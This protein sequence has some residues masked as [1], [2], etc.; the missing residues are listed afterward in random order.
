MS[1]SAS[2]G[3]SDKRGDNLPALKDV[4][5]AHGLSAR[6]SLGQHF[7]LDSGITDRIARTAGEVS[8]VNVIEIGPGPGGLTRSLLAAGAKKIFAVEKDMRC[9]AALAEIK[10]MAGGRLEIIEADAL[11]TDVTA[12]VP[13][14]RRIVANL[15]YNIGTE[16]LLGWLDAIYKDPNV[17][18]S[19]T[20]MF[21]KEVAERIAARPSTK[22]YGRLSV[23]SQWLCETRLEFELP[24][25]A[26]SPPPK[27]S[28][29]VVTLTPRAAPLIDVEKAVLEKVMAAAFGQRRKMLRQSLKPLGGEALLKEAGIDPTQRPEQLDVATLCNLAKTYQRLLTKAAS[30]A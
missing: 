18:L 26:F 29:S 8:Q 4:I 21:Q 20:L 13:P 27:V 11:E 17:F 16:L 14:P 1:S 2:T 5:A 23:I 7:L 9:I 24:P 6:K 28:S 30:P 12:W 3:P 15:P 25:S 10:E 22:D 19:L